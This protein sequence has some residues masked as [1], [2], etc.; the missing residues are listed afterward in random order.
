[1]FNVNKIQKKEEIPVFFSSMF[2]T[3]TQLVKSAACLIEINTQKRRNSIFSKLYVLNI[4]TT[5]D[6]Q[7]K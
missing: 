7:W 5:C 3:V 1:M 2:S 6:A 4:Y